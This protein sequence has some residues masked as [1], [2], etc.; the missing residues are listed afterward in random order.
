MQNKD[1]IDIADNTSN[2]QNLNRSIQ[3]KVGQHNISTLHLKLF[4]RVNLNCK[5]Y[6][7]LRHFGFISRKF[8][9]K[10]IPAITQFLSQIPDGY[11][12]LTQNIVQYLKCAPTDVVVVKPIYQI[13]QVTYLTVSCSKAQAL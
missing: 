5:Q 12:H 6:L 2:F 9:N 11:I 3:L 7:N 4:V 1:P 10:K 8:N 13:L